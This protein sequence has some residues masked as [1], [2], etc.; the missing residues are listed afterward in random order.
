MGQM[1]ILVINVIDK[2]QQMR[3]PQKF[4]KKKRIVFVK[5]ETQA[6]ACSFSQLVMS[7]CGGQFHVISHHAG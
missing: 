3:K 6:D 2:N 4:W 5:Y 7:N 1:S